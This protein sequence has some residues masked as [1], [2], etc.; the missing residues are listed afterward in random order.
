[1]FSGCPCGCTRCLSP[2]LRTRSTLPQERIAELVEEGSL[3]EEEAAAKL[4]G[5]TDR[6]SERVNTAG[7]TERMEGH[8]DRGR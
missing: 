5:I 7:P 8:R 1:M 6:V 3:T 2:D 4:A